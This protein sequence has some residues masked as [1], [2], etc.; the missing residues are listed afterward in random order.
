MARGDQEIQ[1]GWRV[2]GQGGNMRFWHVLRASIRMNV[3]T[4]LAYRSEAVVGILMAIFWIVYELA[5]IGIIFSNTQTIG[6]WGFGEIVALTGVWKLMNG[7]MFAWL[8]PNTEKF[9]Q[10]VRDGTL[11][12]VF[13]Q[14]VNSQ[15]IVS[16][17]R[18]MLWRLVEQIFA[19]GMIV[20]GLSMSSGLSSISNVLSF[21][22][23]TISGVVII[24]SAW[25]ILISLT[26]WFTKFDNSVTILQALMDSGRFPATVYPAWLRA[27]ITFVVPIAIAMTVPLQALRGELVWWQVLAFLA[28]GVAMF[29]VSAAVW[30]AGSKRY[31]GASS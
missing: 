9:N 24:Y 15:L 23:L 1:R 18:F 21:L 31:A 26:F 5:S 29:L 19:I 22:L 16:I 28:I 20:I 12:Y 6:G 7:F 13:L 3:Q 2:I 8:W 27:I 11:D 14:P 30:R 10:G 25:I 4:D 17:N